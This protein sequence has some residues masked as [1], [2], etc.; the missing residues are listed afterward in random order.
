LDASDELETRSLLVKILSVQAVV[1]SSLGSF[2]QT[3]ATLEEALQRARADGLRRLQCS[4]LG[5]LGG[6]EANLGRFANALPYYDQCLAVSQEVGFTLSQATCH[7]NLARCNRELGDA[8]SAEHHVHLG[9]E[10]AISI[11]MRE[12]EGRCHLLMGHLRADAGDF[13]AAHLAYELCVARFEA[14]DLAH[15]AAQGYAGR[16]A[17]ALEA[18]DLEGARHWAERADEAA[19]SGESLY[20]VEDPAWVPVVCHRVWHRCGDARAPAAIAQAYRGLQSLLKRADTEEERQIIQSARLHREV[21]AA[22]E[23]AKTAEP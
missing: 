3:R 17:L 4:I 6:L 11:A 18:G 12:L 19:G 20:A 23:A 15:F 2:A 16:A 21:L 22:W 9:L 1:F 10:Q 5:N 7:H 14:A 13:E 8:T